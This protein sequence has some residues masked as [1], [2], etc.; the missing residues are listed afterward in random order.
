MWLRVLASSAIAMAMGVSMALSPIAFAQGEREEPAAANLATMALAADDL[1]PGF[2]LNEAMSEVSDG[3]LHIAY[4]V[5]APRELS[6]EGGFVVG[7]VIAPGLPPDRFLD[8]AF[9]HLAATLAR[10]DPP[11]TFAPDPMEGPAEGALWHALTFTLLGR[12][13][14]G[15]SA[16]FPLA[17]GTGMVLTVGFVGRTT[18]DETAGL[19]Q[20]VTER[21]AKMPAA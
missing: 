11:T 10:A 4:Y 13:A 3:G 2:L 14:Q 21:L 12:P 15:Y 20:L 7:V 5:R 1:P 6:A 8:L 18:L 9:A 19:W 17:N 16:T